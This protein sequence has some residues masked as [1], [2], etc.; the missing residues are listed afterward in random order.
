MQTH[1]PVFI[2][3]TMVVIS[4]FNVCVSVSLAPRFTPGFKSGYILL[5][6]QPLLIAQTYSHIYNI[7][8]LYLCTQPLNACA[9]RT[10]AHLAMT[11]LDHRHTVVPVPCA[12]LIPTWAKC[13]ICAPENRHKRLSKSGPICLPD[14]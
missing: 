6:I 11:C 8:A 2:I 3:L 1:N 12:S 5:T 13:V 10:E 7:S 9:L 4:R 14:P